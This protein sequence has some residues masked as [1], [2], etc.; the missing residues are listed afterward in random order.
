MN[1][2]NETH[3]IG[4]NNMPTK[5]ELKRRHEERMAKRAEVANGLYPSGV[6]Y[7]SNLDGLIGHLKDRN[8][9]LYPT[10]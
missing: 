2:T 10:I 6:E 4:T 3:I 8:E 1:N 7:K 9:R 5:A